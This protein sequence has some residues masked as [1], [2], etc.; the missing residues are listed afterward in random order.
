MTEIVT[1]IVTTL[2]VLGVAYIGHLG[3]KHT[4]KASREANADTVSATEQET[5][6][7]ALESMTLNLLEPYRQEVDLLRKRVKHVEDSR[8]TERRDRE[9]KAREIQDQITRQTERI[10]LL[11]VEVRHWK[12][13][14]KAI[15]RWATTLRDQVISLGGSVPSIPDELLV[16][17]LLDEREEDGL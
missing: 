4:G 15:A 17:Q 7:K 16:A 3:I 13:M 10:D 8:A 1:A 9:E 5:A 12:A 14:A 2:G 6:V 11:T